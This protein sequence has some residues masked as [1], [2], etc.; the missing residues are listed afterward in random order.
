MRRSFVAQP[1]W[2][3]LH[4]LCTLECVWKCCCPTSWDCCMN[5]ARNAA[6][7]LAPFLFL[8][9][10]LS[11]SLCPQTEETWP[12]TLGFSTRAQSTS[13]SCSP[14][15][16]L[17]SPEVFYS[18]CIHLTFFFLLMGLVASG[19]GDWCLSGNL[20]NTDLQNRCMTECSC[21]P[22]HGFGCA[23]TSTVPMPSPQVTTPSLSLFSAPCDTHMQTHTHLKG[24]N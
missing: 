18:L 15:C 19:G 2:Y 5:A 1:D 3:V 6:S 14:A 13:F 17:P 8:T 10:L 23:P 24:V 4:D 22:Q 7:L 21:H 20:L 11:I 9:S 16:L 12:L